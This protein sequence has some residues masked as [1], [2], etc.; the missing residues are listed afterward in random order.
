MIKNKIINIF[1]YLLILC[2]NTIPMQAMDTAEDTKLDFKHYENSINSNYTLK[3]IEA[4]DR[5][6]NDAPI[7]H[8]CYTLV[9]YDKTGII[10]ELVVVREQQNKGL[11]SQ[12]FL[13]ALDDARTKNMQN[14]EWSSTRKALNFYKR[15]GANIITTPLTMAN[16]LSLRMKFVF[17]QDGD[18]KENLK[19]YYLS[20]LEN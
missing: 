7:G 3:T 10:Q 19:Q 20:S 18:P 1:I 2:I 16:S 12:L 9:P 14:V 4:Y 17:D 5:H 11:G 15:F 13:M 8:I 6:L